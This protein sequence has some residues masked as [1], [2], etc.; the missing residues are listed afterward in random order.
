MSDDAHR[1]VVRYV[2]ERVYRSP[3]SGCWLWTGN[4]W[5]GY[6]RAWVAG[7]AWLAHR[8]VYHYLVAHLPR[9]TP[10]HHRCGVR[11]CVRPEHLQ[12]VTLAENTAE[13]MQ[14]HDLYDRLAGLEDRLRAA[15]TE[16]LTAGECADALATELEALGWTRW[17]LGGTWIITPPGVS[18]SHPPHR[19]CSS[20]GVRP[21]YG[22]RHQGEKALNEE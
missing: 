18:T 8:L 4:R 16:A 21:T 2:M 5:N 13:M 1:A 6:G 12:A 11:A 3:S 14:R 20:T 19:V 7:D 9:A 10:V 22:H 17:D 15:S